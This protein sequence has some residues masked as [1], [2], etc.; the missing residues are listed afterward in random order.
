MLISVRGWP[1]VWRGG[2]V[3]LASRGYSGRWSGNAY[4]PTRSVGMR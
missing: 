3:D 2:S 1:R 4:I